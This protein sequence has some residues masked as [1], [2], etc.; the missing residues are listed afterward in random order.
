MLPE[1][2]GLRIYQ[3]RSPKMGCH[4]ALYTSIH[5]GYGGRKTLKL[6]LLF[7]IRV[8]EYKANIIHKIIMCHCTNMCTVL[9]I[10]TANIKHSITY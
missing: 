10:L 7:Q 8:L 1:Q 2:A 3:Y 6:K 9:Y 5:T 4:P